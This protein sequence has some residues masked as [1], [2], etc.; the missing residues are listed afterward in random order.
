MYFD[1]DEYPGEYRRK[2]HGEADSDYQDETDSGY[3]DEARQHEYDWPTEKTGSRKRKKRRKKH[4]FLRFLLIVLV[5]VGGYF[6]AMSGLFSIGTIDVKDSSFAGAADETD[7][8]GLTGAA[9]TAGA[10]GSTYFTAAQIIELSGISEGANMWKTDMNEAERRIEES[11][12]V[13]SCEIARKPFHRIIITVKERS[14]A[15]VIKSEDEYA[16]LDYEGYV[17]RTTDEPGHMPVIENIGLEKAVPGQAAV[18]GQN[19]LLTDVIT[20]LRQAEASDIYFK[21]IVCSDVTVLAYIYDHLTCRGTFKN[22]TDNMEQL[23]TVYLDLRHEK[24][25]RGMI[26]VSGN[27]TCTFSPEEAAEQ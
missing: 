17:L 1:E 24:I 22:L 8:A 9:V 18:V 13:K 4:Y 10:A 2:Y 20:F 23:R 12:Y 6:L 16:V 19:L 26:I 25:S 5:C 7:A 11:P 14:E 3:S 15:F 27:G 21:R